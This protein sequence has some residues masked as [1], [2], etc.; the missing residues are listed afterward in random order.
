MAKPAKVRRT[1]GVENT[2]PRSLMARLAALQE[3]YAAELRRSG[4]AS[5]LVAAPQPRDE[6]GSNQP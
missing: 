5:A 2:S 4:G 6:D 3:E 1:A